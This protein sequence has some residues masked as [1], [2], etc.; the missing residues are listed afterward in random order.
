MSLSLRNLSLTITVLCAAAPLAAQ[1]RH[2]AVSLDD[3]LRMALSESP[4][5]DIARAGVVRATGQV[6]QAHSQFLPQIAGSAGYT[7]T[8]RSQFQG[9]FGSSS[10][11]NSGTGSGSSTGGLDLSQAGFGAL[12]QWTVGASVSQNLFTGGRMTSQRAAADAQAR[13]ASVEVSSQQAQLALT[14]TQAYYDA[15][16]TD[17]LVAIAD[18][19]LAETDD[20][21]RQ[22][23]LQRQVG[24]AAEYDLLRA[25][26]ARDNQVPV[27]L[28]AKSGRQVAYL[29]LKQ[30]LNLS[31]DDSVRLTTK[32]DASGEPALPQ[33]AT[34]PTDTL[35]GDRAPV[36]ELQEAVR[37]QEAQL[38]V[39]KSE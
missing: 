16:L 29:R 33:S 13:S 5:I 4:T 30:L 1:Q 35:V 18:S 37:A 32:L 36:R 11:G 19:A 24:N 3:A 8:L 39:A 6:A 12:N 23:Q 21:L 7:R 17:Q 15:I 28:Q 2:V 22:T 26:V 10:S 9:I 38:R 25:Q 34:A 31:L 27:L 20:I 14:V